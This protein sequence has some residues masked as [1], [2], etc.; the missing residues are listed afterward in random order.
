MVDASTSMMQGKTG[1]RQYKSCS[2]IA[3]SNNH[4]RRVNCATLDAIWT[5]EDASGNQTYPGPRVE[6]QTATGKRQ[7]QGSNETP[8]GWHGRAGLQPPG[9]SIQNRFESPGFSALS[10][11]HK[12]L[13]ILLFLM[14]FW[15]VQEIQTRVSTGISS[16]RGHGCQWLS[17]HAAVSTC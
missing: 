15:R 5:S 7:P 8:T 12:K 16:R 3:A 14:N 2:Y 17:C 10:K 1:A 11:M 6:R 13:L 4:S 9:R